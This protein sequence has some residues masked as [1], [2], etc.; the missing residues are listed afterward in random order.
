MYYKVTSLLER[1][2]IKM[3]NILDP[4][5]KYHPDISR[6]TV[7]EQLTILNKLFNEKML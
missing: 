1:D 6:N 7:P 2:K 4:H 5:I 3:L